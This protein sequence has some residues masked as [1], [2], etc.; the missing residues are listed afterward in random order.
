MWVHH[1]LLHIQ[2]GEGPKGFSWVPFALR[3]HQ[4]PPLSVSHS[5]HS[6]CGESCAVT[7]PSIPGR[8]Q[9]QFSVF[10]VLIYLGCLTLSISE[11]TLWRLGARPLLVSLIFFLDYSLPQPRVIL[12]YL[13]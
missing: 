13:V 9:I 6:G 5:P 2:G 1:V 3:L 4:P 7:A 11:L 8:K 10:R 12:T